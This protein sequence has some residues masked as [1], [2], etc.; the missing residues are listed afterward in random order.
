MAETHRWTGKSG[1]GY[2]YYVYEIGHPMQ[3][4]DGNYIYAK[5]DTYGTWQP[6]YIGQ[7]NLRDRSDTGSHHKGGCINRNEATHFHAHLNALQS[8]RQAEELDLLG[9]WATPCNG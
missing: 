4:K 8:S 1:N 5:A 6:V 3:D 2:T 7:G 9:H